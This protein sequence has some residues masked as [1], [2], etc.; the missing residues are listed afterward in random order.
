MFLGF[1]AVYVDLSLL[2]PWFQGVSHRADPN[3]PPVIVDELLRY[4]FAE[5]HLV[6]YLVIKKHQAYAE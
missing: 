3:H 4:P 6:L 2:R 5:G 1:S